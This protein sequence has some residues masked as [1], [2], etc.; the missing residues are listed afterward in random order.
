MT[1]L[2]I[3]LPVLPGSLT[4]R[5]GQVCTSRAP[6]P[7]MS[8]ATAVRPTGAAADQRRLEKSLAGGKLFVMMLLI[9]GERDV[10]TLE[11]VHSAEQR[12]MHVYDG[13]N[14]T[15]PPPGQSAERAAEAIHGDNCHVGNDWTM[16]HA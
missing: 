11:G 4:R 15:A 13:G 16:T 7:L 3:Y 5:G 14:P 10:T 12:V 8:T 2:I 1:G 9:I 6:A